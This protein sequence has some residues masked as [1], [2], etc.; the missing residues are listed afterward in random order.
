M[1]KNV[2]FIYE[3]NIRDF[4]LN[5][6]FYLYDDIIRDFRLM[7]EGLYIVW[8]FGYYFLIFLKLYMLKDN[9]YRNFFL[10]FYYMLI[11]YF[12]LYI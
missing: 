3:L 11:Y 4:F 12:I 5:V 8:F 10:K 6:L 1:Y 2:N 9:F 7:K